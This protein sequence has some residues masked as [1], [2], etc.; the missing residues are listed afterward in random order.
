MS[1]EIRNSVNKIRNQCDKI[2][3]EITPKRA[4]TY[5]DPVVILSE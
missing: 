1:K 3:E 2:E 5:G 4:K